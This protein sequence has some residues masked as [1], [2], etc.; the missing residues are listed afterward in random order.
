MQRNG[1]IFI[2]SLFI[3]SLVKVFIPK[4]YFYGAIVILFALFLL[5]WNIQKVQESDPSKNRTRLTMMALIASGYLL[6]GIIALFI[7]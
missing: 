4:G 6:S 3:G 2:L 7:K 1:L 5:T